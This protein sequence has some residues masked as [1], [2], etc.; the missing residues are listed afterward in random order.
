MR[1]CLPA[2]MGGG[3]KAESSP[4]RGP[5]GEARHTGA[6]I[7]LWETRGQSPWRSRATRKRRRSASPSRNAAQATAPLHGA[8]PA[9]RPA[10]GPVGQRAS[11]QSRGGSVSGSAQKR[12]TLRSAK[13]G[14]ECDF[15]KSRS[16]SPAPDRHPN[17]PG[18]QAR[19]A[20]RI[21]RVARRA[22]KDSTQ[23]KMPMRY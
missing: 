20:T 14:T 11:G 16:S 5:A 15:R 9:G 22:A 2:R 23:Q 17:G 6:T 7:L 1:L 4:R 18:P 13:R 3:G 21:E 12:R 8:T 19:F 10:R